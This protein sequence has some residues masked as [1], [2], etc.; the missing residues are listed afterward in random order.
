MKK[1][2]KK[3]LTLNYLIIFN[4]LLIFLISKYSFAN[5]QLFQIEGNEFTDNDVILSLLKNIPESVNKEYTNEIIKSLNESNLFSNINVKINNNKFIISVEEYPSLNKIT[6][7][8]N[9]RLKD[10]ELEL[11]AIDMNLINSNKVLIQ[12]FIS[13]IKK[14]YESFG[15]NN[16]AIDYNL[17][18]NE[19]TNTADI[20]F[21][22][23][24]GQITKIN[25]I[26]FQEM[27]QYYL[28]ILNQSLHQ[29]P[30]Q[31]EIFL[32][33]IILNLL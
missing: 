12:E 11:L 24:E 9:E 14:I 30:K 32:Q 5:D 29:R 27:I 6:F 22:F 19:N 3:L 1:L 21:D 20:N 23:T 17:Q 26:I 2:K 7:N 10:E 16:V 13:E 33:I 4:F 8:N 25:R 31:F 28:M 15:Y 18:I